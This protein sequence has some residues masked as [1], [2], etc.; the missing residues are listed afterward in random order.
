MT[1][2]P[3][4][5]KLQPRHL[6]RVY[7]LS[8]H[9]ADAVVPQE[10]GETPVQK[11]EVGVKTCSILLGKIRE[12]LRLAAEE[13]GG[14]DRSSQADTSD[15]GDMRSVSEA[16]SD[17]GG[18][19]EG[20]GYR[21]DRRLAKS[22]GIKNANRHVRT[23]LYFTSES[24]LHAVLNVLR[25]AH[26]AS[27]ALPKPADSALKR[28]AEMNELSYLCHIVVRLFEV[29]E[30]D[31][32]KHH[33]VR[34]YVSDGISIKVIEPENGRDDVAVIVGT[35]SAEPKE[36]PNVQ[37][38]DI[39]LHPSGFGFSSFHQ[40]IPLS[41]AASVGSRKLGT[42]GG[43]HL[44][45]LPPADPLVPLWPQIALGDA[46]KLFDPTLF[47]LVPPPAP[48]PVHA[49]SNIAPLKLKKGFSLQRFESSAPVFKPSWAQTD[50]DSDIV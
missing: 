7:E 49:G 4:I 15:V 37:P 6:L 25:Y 31:G 43:H 17:E 36:D 9:L 30:P 16:P 28:L 44:K 13:G 32:S 14:G 5:L 3:E 46:L 29:T 8:K 21:L 42:G 11:F 12:D 18:F 35:Q 19:V 45:F 47:D 39:D 27:A 33:T 20:A 1:H 38:K 24:H 50:D 10:Y 40:N 23:R 22:M 34:I 41:P 48:S 2:N 26:L